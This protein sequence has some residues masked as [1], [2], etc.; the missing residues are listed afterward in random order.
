ML[1][2]FSY[3]LAITHMGPRAS[4]PPLIASPIQCSCFCRP[5]FFCSPY[6]PKWFNVLLPLSKTKLSHHHCL[7]AP[8]QAAASSTR[9]AA[10]S[11]PSQGLNSTTFCFLCAFSWH[12]FNELNAMFWIWTCIYAL[13]ERGQI[14]RAGK[15]SLLQV[16]RMGRG[17]RAFPTH[18]RQA[19]ENLGRR[20]TFPHLGAA[21]A[22]PFAA[23]TAWWFWEEEGVF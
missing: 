13:K 5:Y 15:W 3:C 20:F 18:T 23:R 21:S 22:I 8:V 16:F 1:E 9:S 17:W 11:F 6:F 7:A 10:P 12:D 19:T 4:P 14:D 2:S